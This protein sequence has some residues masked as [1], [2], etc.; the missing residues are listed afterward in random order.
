MMESPPRWTETEISVQRKK[1]S[2]AVSGVL[3]TLRQYLIAHVKAIDQRPLS[4]MHKRLFPDAI[5]APSQTKFYSDV[6]KAG[7]TAAYLTH[8]FYNNIQHC[9]ESFSLPPTQVEK[10]MKQT[11]D[12]R[13]YCLNLNDAAKFAP[14]EA[15]LKSAA[16]LKPRARRFRFH[17]KSFPDILPAKGIYEF[18]TEVHRKNEAFYSANPEQLFN[19]ELL[20]YK[21]DYLHSPFWFV[22]RNIV[23]FRDSFLC[24]ICN[25]QA[26]TVHHLYY[27][28]DVLYGRD[29]AALVSLCEPCHKKIEFDSTGGKINDI[30]KKR[31]RYEWLKNGG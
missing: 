12:G 8:H 4:K 29:L 28:P 1:C 9:L 26:T 23:L 15:E 30:E 5:R 14:S 20:D 17:P 10:L 13:R 6:R 7:S 31:Q 18:F 2:E 21:E 16:P 19:L 3:S 25:K 22:I 11:A 27:G 24:R